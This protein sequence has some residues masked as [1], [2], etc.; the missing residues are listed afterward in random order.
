[1]TSNNVNINNKD[2]GLVELNDIT[3]KEVIKKN[4]NKKNKLN[5]FIRKK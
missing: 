1:M 2:Q 4:K 5:I 3:Q